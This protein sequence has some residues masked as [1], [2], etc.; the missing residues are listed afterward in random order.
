M[1]KQIK[2]VQEFHERFGHPVGEVLTELDEKRVEF[3]ADLMAE[4]VREYRHAKTYIDQIDAIVD[5][6][7]FAY[8][9]LV[10]MGIRDTTAEKCFQLVH[11][12]NMAKLGPDGKPIYNERGKVMKPQGWIGPED[13][14]RKHLFGE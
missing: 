8:G 14:L 9:T 11:D 12:A 4:E 3:R 5:L 6:L 13:R 2:M 7:Y 1:K 10:E